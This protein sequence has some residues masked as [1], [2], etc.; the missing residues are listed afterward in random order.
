M[1]QHCAK[2]LSHNTYLR[3]VQFLSLPPMAQHCAKS[4]SHNTYLRLV[5]LL[6]LPPMAQ[7][8]ANPL[9]L[10]SDWAAKYLLSSNWSTQYLLNAHWWK[11]I[12][13]CHAHTAQPGRLN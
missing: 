5:Q 10:P 6:S 1:A 13:H 8:R 11:P 7:H 3:L 9:S 4:L 2:S 12:N